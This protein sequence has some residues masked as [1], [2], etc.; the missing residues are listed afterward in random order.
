M[1]RL[2]RLPEL[3]AVLAEEARRRGTTP[4]LLAELLR[5][6]V[7]PTDAGPHVVGAAPEDCR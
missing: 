5:E 1:M 3:E 6:E 4:E 7:L 2:T